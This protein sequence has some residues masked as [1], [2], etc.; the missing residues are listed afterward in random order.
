MSF[1]NVALCLG[2]LIVGSVGGAI[3][4]YFFAKNKYQELADK[5]IESVKKVYEDHFK[6]NS[7]TKV[8]N[9]EKP[10]DKAAESDEKVY[11]DYTN[12]YKGGN[13]TEE[14]PPEILKGK[15][16]K[17]PSVT[18]GKKPP[19]IIDGLQLGELEGYTVADLFYYADKVL[20]DQDGN[21]VSNING[22]I[23]PDALK[24]FVGDCDAVYVRN[25]DHQVDYEI[26]LSDKNYAD[27][28]D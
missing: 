22:T 14:L 27:R 7:D 4:G 24:K 5:E 23:G 11:T 20:A 19:Y 25:E 1:R 13:A 18:T 3:A 8:I 28:D 26:L 9:N 17:K 21:I 10:V 15:D 2:S 16:P 12:M 6:K